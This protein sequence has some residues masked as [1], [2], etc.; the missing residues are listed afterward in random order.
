MTRFSVLDYCLA[1]AASGVVTFVA[2]PLVKRWATSVG[3]V[4]EPDPSRHVHTRPTPTLGGIAMYYGLLA[5]IVVGLITPETRSVLLSSSEVWG[6]LLGASVIFG[7]GAIDDFHDISPPAKTAGQVLAGVLLAIFGVAILYFR[8]WPTDHF[9]SLGRAGGD[10]AVVVTVLW[11]IG[12]S[13]AINLIDGLD[14]LA[15]GIVA[16]ASASIFVFVWLFSPQGI[17]SPTST[18]PFVVS[19]TFGLACGFLPWNFHP[20]RVFMGDSGALLLGFLM[21]AATVAIGGQSPDLF[22]GKTYFFFGPLLIPLVI[23][24]IPLL[25]TAYAFVRR[26]ASKRSWSAGDKE[27]LHHRLLHMGHGHRRSVLILWGW[28]AL[29]SAVVLVPAYTGRGNFLVLG[30]VPAAAL[31]LLTLFVPGKSNEE[32]E[33]PPEDSSAERASGEPIVGFSGPLGSANGVSAAARMEAGAQGL[34]QGSSRPD[35]SRTERS[36]SEAT[37]RNRES[38]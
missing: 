5:G 4:V 18:G 33:G 38:G 35:G 17:I 29:L 37:R 2:T 11:V 27:H 6:I 30:L 34:D 14:G 21:A 36:M 28:T 8:L 13:N 16:I 26:L 22:P 7:V 3:A 31:A 23:L 9:V 15:A 32:A 1:S 24:G 20:A 19:V 12:M 25:D 10:L